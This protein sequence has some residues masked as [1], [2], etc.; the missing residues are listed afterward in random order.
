[1]ALNDDTPFCEGSTQGSLHGRRP[2]E[3]PS[4]AI[5]VSWEQSPR[6]CPLEPQVAAVFTP[7]H[8]HSIVQVS[9]KHLTSSALSLIFGTM[10]RPIARH[11]VRLLKSVT[12]SA[13]DFFA[14]SASI[15]A[16]SDLAAASRIWAEPADAAKKYRHQPISTSRAKTN[17]PPSSALWHRWPHEAARQIE[18]QSAADLQSESAALGLLAS[19]R[20][21]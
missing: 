9:G 11:L 2:L 20:F 14:V 6:L 16:Y 13:R 4:E 19:D 17:R 5:A 8:S 15:H 1:M 7:R 12:E 10:G 18:S 3:Y 21:I